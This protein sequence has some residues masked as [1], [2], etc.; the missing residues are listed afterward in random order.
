MKTISEAM[1]WFDKQPQEKRDSLNKEFGNE[2]VA[3]R[4]MKFYKWLRNKI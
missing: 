1:A 2:G 4:E 3:D